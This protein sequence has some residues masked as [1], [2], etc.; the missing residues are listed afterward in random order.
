VHKGWYSRDHL[1]HL[2]VPDLLQAI[3]FRLA[4]SLPVEVA[5]KLAKTRDPSARSN[6]VEKSLDHGYGSCCLRD[7]GI[8]G[9]VQAS[10]VWGDGDWYRLLAWVVMPNH[11]HAL[12]ETMPGHPIHRI[13]QQW[14]SYT[15]R[16]INPLLGRGGR[17]WQTDFFDRYVRD[18]S[19]YAAALAYIENNPVKADLVSRPE[20]WPLGS[21]RP[22]KQGTD[23][24]VR[25]PQ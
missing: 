20:D 10:L 18:E 24:E 5:A 4:D 12:I 3:T 21:A 23:L 17:L 13:V 25:P 15:A 19:H 22:R 8:G 14:K 2:D 9:I 1:P 6:L 16:R 7:P 11:V